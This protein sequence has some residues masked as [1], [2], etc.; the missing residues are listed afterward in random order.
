MDRSS[1]SGTVFP[2]FSARCQ[3]W[4]GLVCLVQCFLFYAPGVSSGPVWLVWYSVS[5]FLR[6]V[7]AV[8]RS[9]LSGTVF[10]VFSAR[11]QQWTGLVCL[12][13]CFLFYA[14]G[15]GSG[16][17]WFVWYSVSCFLR[18]VSA[19]D[20]SSLSGTVFPVFSARC[21]QWTGLVCLVQ[22]FLFSP[23]GVSSGPV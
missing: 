16:P 7:S 15:V 5:C 21:Q 14:P 2:V 13:Q 23:P 20:R 18:Q 8:D 22:C 4:T 1:L 19:V 17:V 6:Q 9:S 12:V 11:C 10:P 3:Q